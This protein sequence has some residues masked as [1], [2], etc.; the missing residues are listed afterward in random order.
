MRTGRPDGLIG[1]TWA[2]ERYQTLWVNEHLR[3]QRG[4]QMLFEVKSS[5]PSSRAGR[6][7]RKAWR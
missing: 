4:K 7:R 6:S 5:K 1:W 2:R 3:V